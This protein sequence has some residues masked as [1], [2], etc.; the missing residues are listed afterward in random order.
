VET[1]AA[2]TLL[3]ESDPPPASAWDLTVVED[4]VAAPLPEPTA[5]LSLPEAFGQTT[6]QHPV[7][8]DSPAPT[9]QGRLKI[10]CPHCECRGE[11]PWGRLGSLLCCTS[12]CR[13]YR[14][15]TAGRLIETAAPKDFAKGSLRFYRSN[16]G[17]GIVP[18]T[19]MDLA[20]NR[21][22]RWSLARLL[23][24]DPGKLLSFSKESLAVAVILV[25][26]VGIFAVCY[27]Q[28][29]GPSIGDRRPPPP[30]LSQ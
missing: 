21:Q 10:L 11:L 19:S 24:S 25:Y 22:R 12:C 9:I 3:D 1:S 6:Y 7:T 16:G 28:Y 13:W 5:N 14:C 17:E 8:A 26:L 23:P 4:A 29:M 30:V 20:K 15:D 2:E 18:L 27:W